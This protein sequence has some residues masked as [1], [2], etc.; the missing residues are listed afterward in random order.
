MDV[1]GLGCLKDAFLVL[2]GTQPPTAFDPADLGP[3]HVEMMGRFLLMEDAQVNHSSVAE[4]FPKIGLCID[5]NSSAAS[6]RRKASNVFV[7]DFIYKDGMSACLCEFA[8][9]NV[10]DE[11]RRSD[12][13]YALVPLVADCLKAKLD[14]VFHDQTGVCLGLLAMAAVW[15]SFTGGEMYV[16]DVEVNV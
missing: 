15:K 3:F 13:L 10:F 11:A 7:S 2:G 8:G 12:M 9:L 6:L 16:S 5:C 4:V 1:A 14:V